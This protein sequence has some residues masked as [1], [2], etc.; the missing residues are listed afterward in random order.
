[1]SMWLLNNNKTKRRLITKKTNN[2]RTRKNQTDGSDTR[3]VTIRDK[4]PLELRL[5]GGVRLVNPCGSVL[6]EK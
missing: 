1:M 3:G 6:D 5:P 4:N 2:T